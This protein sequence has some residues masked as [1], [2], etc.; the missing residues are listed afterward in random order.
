MLSL[1]PISA[2]DG[3]IGSEKQCDLHKDTQQASVRLWVYQTPCQVLFA[4]HLT[5]SNVPG[6]GFGWKFM[7]QKQELLLSLFSGI[8]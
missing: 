6:L 1:I 2:D 4:L 8:P 5:A 7:K 3:H